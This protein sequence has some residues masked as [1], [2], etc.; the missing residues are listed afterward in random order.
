MRFE[1]FSNGAG[2]RSS[3]GAPKGRPKAG[4]A[5]SSPFDHAARQQQRPRQQQGAQPGSPFRTVYSREAAVNIDGWVLSG[6]D[7][8]V[9]AELL[10]LE[11]LEELVNA[12]E[13]EEEDDVE[14]EEEE[15]V[16]EEETQK[17]G[18]TAQQQHQAAGRGSSRGRDGGSA[19]AGGKRQMGDDWLW[20]DSDSDDEDVN[21]WVREARRYYGEVG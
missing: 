12:I 8:E 18:R 6:E 1:Q 19:A 21:D 9:V 3:S 7:L 17:R 14:E 4:A 13:T 20:D 10:G 2:T 15:E 5:S 11:D 16:V